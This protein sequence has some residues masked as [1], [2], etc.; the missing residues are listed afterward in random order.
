MVGSEEPDDS[1][2]TRRHE[3]MEDVVA[4]FET[5]LLRYAARLLN[6]ASMAQDV[7]QN[8]FVKLFRQ[9]PPGMQADPRLKS[10]LYRVTHNEAVD[11]LRSEHRRRRLHDRQAVETAWCRDGVHCD[12][13][14]DDRVARVMHC[15]GVLALPER[16]VLLLRLQEG[17][18]YEEIASVTGHSCGYVG[19]LLHHAVKKLSASVKQEEGV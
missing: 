14:Q 11:L 5:P 8:V 18:S 15:L 4:A 10:W 13:P 16:Q 6:N 12:A 19:S 7:V 1:P 3:Y 17:L 9:W 2:R